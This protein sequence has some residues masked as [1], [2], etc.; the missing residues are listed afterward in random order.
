[1]DLKCKLKPETMKLLGKT[2]ENSLPFVLVM[3]FGV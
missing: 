3:V 1:M 2:G